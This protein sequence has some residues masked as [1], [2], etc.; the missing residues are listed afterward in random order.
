[1][2]GVGDLRDLLRS[3]EFRQLYA[4]RLVSATGDGI[5]QA[6][7]ASYVLFNPEKATTP[8]ETASALAALLLPYS[9]VGPFVGVFL[10]RWS[11]QRV[12]VVS[13]LVKVALVVAVAALVAA[14]S[15]GAAFFVAAV[16]ALGVNRLFLSALS[17]GLPHVVSPDELVTANALSTTS[18]SIA[19]I[20]GAGIGGLLRFGIGSGSRAVAVIV[21]VA[22]AVYATSAS[23]AARM[24][25]TLLGP[26]DDELAS[27]SSVSTWRAMARVSGDLRRAAMHLVR[28][29]RAADA[30][31]AISAHRFLYGVATLTIV[32]LNRNYFTNNINSGLL[33]L[34]A[35]V[36][37][38]GVGILVAAVVTP[39]ATRR[40]GKR[41]WI[42]WLLLAAAIAIAVFGLPFRRALL[43]VGAFLLG[44][45][46]QGVKISVDTTVQEEVA[47]S[48]R[49]RVFSVYDMLFNVTYVAAAAV[50]ATALPKSG[51]S[52]LVMSLLAAGY[53]LAGLAFALLSARHR[54]GSSDRSTTRPAA[55]ESVALA[56]SPAPPSPA[57]PRRAT[58][59]FGDPKSSSQ[60]RNR[61]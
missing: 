58:G 23:V 21:I 55:V 15:E 34:G 30:L 5:F 3:W 2:P 52:Y 16:A 13:N 11:R 35:V 7:L 12:L 59:A 50:T 31:F 4:T 22:A 24:S 61:P 29:R 41:R 43:V 32:L 1:V 18:G 27:A 51:K 19:T 45:S 10:D 44:V 60:G 14:R 8:A 17:A 47:D 38:S 6:A 57:P 25:R 48:F 49:G 20:A 54:D 42:T 33:G 28:R 36:G 40:F 39:S 9:L 53:L 46:A 56:G 37:A 26:D